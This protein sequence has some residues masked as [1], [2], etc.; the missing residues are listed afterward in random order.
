MSRN[1]RYL[2]NDHLAK[3]AMSLHLMLQGHSD[4][5]GFD[6]EVFKG[7][8]IRQG[9]KEFEVCR[10]T[11][12]LEGN[13]TFPFYQIFARKTPDRYELNP[14][15]KQFYAMFRNDWEVMQMIPAD[16]E[17]TPKPGGK[18]ALAEVSESWEVKVN[19]LAAMLTRAT[20]TWGWQCLDYKMQAKTA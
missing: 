8:D 11:T 7:F 12:W 15:R 2:M 13:F 6:E 10:A 1:L 3:L 19:P 5:T 14:E 18:F 17:W 4:V 20:E 16:V 9:K